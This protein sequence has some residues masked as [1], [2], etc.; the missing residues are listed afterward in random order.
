MLEGTHFELE[1]QSFWTQFDSTICLFSVIE[2]HRGRIMYLTYEGSSV[3]KSLFVVGKGVTYDTGG[4]DIKAG[5]IMAGMSRDKCGAAAVAGLMKVIIQKFIVIIM[6][7]IQFLPIIRLFYHYLGFI[8][9][10]T[11]KSKSCW[12][13]VY[14]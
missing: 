14:G 8:Y 5:G 13:H 1:S 10:E 2:R 9:F 3:N 4:A 12:S 7:S 11:R 6:F